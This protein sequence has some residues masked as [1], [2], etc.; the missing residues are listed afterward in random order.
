MTSKQV[1]RYRM[2]CNTEAAYQYCW[3]ESL[4]TACPNNSSHVID[5]DT[6][7]ILDT[8]SSNAVEIVQQVGTGN[9]YACQS[10]C[11][12]VPANSTVVKDFSWP[13]PVSISTMHFT[14]DSSQVGD[15]IT[16]TISPNTVIGTLTKN[17][18]ASGTILSLCPETMQNAVIGT[19]ATLSDGS[20]TVDCG[21]FYNLDKQNNT[22]CIGNPPGVPFLASSPTQVMLSFQNISLEVG[23]PSC[24]TFGSQQLKGAAMPPNT[25]MRITYINQSGTVTKRFRG[26]G[27]LAY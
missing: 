1:N 22:L 7:N 4:P 11:F 21:A 25:I 3:N 14:S 13:F 2:Y 19:L 27:E 17:L 10:F 9:N 15:H 23:Q 18:D 24:Y 12:D 20:N 8:V 6:I 16:G 5:T 26:W